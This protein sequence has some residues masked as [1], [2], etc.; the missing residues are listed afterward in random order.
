MVVF[1][2]IINN[3]SIRRQRDSV[4]QVYNMLAENPVGIRSPASPSVER[5]I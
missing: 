4:N 2:R 3:L 1:G 5:D